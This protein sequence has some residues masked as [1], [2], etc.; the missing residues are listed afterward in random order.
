MRA[1]SPR[2]I[3][4]SHAAARRSSSTRAKARTRRT[5]GRTAPARRSTLEKVE[6]LVNRVTG[7]RAELVRE[8]GA[9]VTQDAS[10]RRHD[11][12]ERQQDGNGHVR[13]HRHRRL[14][15]TLR[16]TRIREDRWH[17]G[18][19]R[20]DES[21]G[22]GEVTCNA[23]CTMQNANRSRGDSRRCALFAFCILHLALA[24]AAPRP[25][26]SPRLSSPSP[27]PSHS[28]SRTSSA[29]TRMPGVSR[30][31]WG[32]AVQSLDRRRAAVRAERRHAAGAGL[33][34]Q[35]RQRRHRGRCGG[36][37]L[38]VRDDPSRH[39]ADRGR[40][41]SRRSARGRLRRSLDRWTRRRRS[42][43]VG[44][45]R[46][47]LLASVAS[48]VASSATTIAIDEPRPQL[49][50]AWDDLGYTTGALFGALNLAENRMHGDDCARPPRPARLRSSRVDPRL[51]FRV[52]TNRVATGPR[53]LA[54]TALARA[55]SG[56]ASSRL[57]ARFR[58]AAPPALLGVAVGNPT[59]WFASAL[60]KPAGPRRHRRQRRRRRHRRRGADAGSRDAATVIYT[61]RS[62]TLA[63]IA[64]PLLKDSINLYAEAL[65]RLNAA[66]RR[67]AHQ[68]RG[69]R[70]F[71]QAARCVGH[72]ECELAARGRLGPVAPRRDLAQSRAV[73]ARADGGSDRQVAVGDRRCRLPASMAR[74]ST[75]MKGTAAESNVRAKTG[76]MSNI[77]TLA[78][79]VDD[80][81]RRA[82]GVRD[83]DQQLRRHRRE[84]ER[85]ARRDRGPARVVLADAVER[86]CVE[87]RLNRS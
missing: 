63:E 41:P 37:G 16:R 28:F 13:P 34:G 80:A 64:Q 84:R 15:G 14:C 39:G 85:R 65:M 36:L 7:L 50:W 40:R 47:R 46:S 3:S 81:R 5:S 83:P 44:G 35:A 73:A 87:T 71:A 82:P 59:L 8:S 58:P 56:R 45:R 21:A 10:A 60:Q 4:S 55:A 19:R 17:G 1:P 24:Q 33:G 11:P 42:L 62:R 67:V 77:R 27:I 25:R 29:A 75:R 69:A 70:G 38:P 72:L 57:P 6:D 68:R 20:G 49:A 66:P 48:T 54:A 53:R 2:R 9:R 52:V 12:L 23:K 30:A 79:Y 86:V 78:G 32:I 26:Q 31:A 22:R 51:A 18:A 61:H 76:T 43:G 74:S